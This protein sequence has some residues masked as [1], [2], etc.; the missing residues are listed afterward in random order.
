[1]NARLDIYPLLLRI[2]GDRTAE[3]VNDTDTSILLCFEQFGVKARTPQ[4]V[5]LWG[6]SWLIACA[7]DEATDQIEITDFQ[8]NATDC[9]RHAVMLRLTF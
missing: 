1:M 5:T 2:L 7:I 8:G 4:E 9:Y 6:P 3:H